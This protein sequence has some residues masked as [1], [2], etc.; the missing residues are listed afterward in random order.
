MAELIRIALIRRDGGTQPRAAL[1]PATVE[2]Y[3]EA[4]REGV[5]FP[6]IGLVYD[7]TDYWL[8]DGFHRT[9][10]FEAAGIDEIEAEVIAGT[11]RDAVLLA[12]GA[13]ATHGLRRTSDD[14]RRAVLLLLGDEEWGKWS[15]R[16]IAERARVSHTFVAKLRD[17]TG[18]VA[19]E[20]RF[21]TKHGTV[22]T[23]ETAAMGKRAADVATIRSLP[24]QAFY[25]VL[26][27]VKAKRQAGKAERRETRER[28]LGEKIAAANAALPAMAAAG[29]IFPVILGDPEWRFEP[30]SRI[31][32]MDRAPEN[33]YP[34]SATD[35]IASR[36]VH[37]IAAPD[38]T[39]FLWATAPM[40]RQALEV[41]AAWGFAYKTHCIWAKRRKGR[42]RGPGYW[43]TGEHE[44]LLLGTKGSPPAPAPGAQF[45]SF[46][47]ADVGEHSEKPAR[48]YELIEAYFPTLP[49]IE[50]NARAPREGWESW[51]AEA[52]EGAVA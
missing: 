27:D 15:D 45:P 22:S 3:A 26:A 43:F 51:G 17:L 31:T 39:L 30:W 13:N 35:V 41:M 42:A 33:H 9:A 1:D 38:C 2:T 11:R 10:G 52:P 16:E 34:T 48:A 36:P 49:K 44:I 37:L 28:E 32:G 5:R 25:D 23:M 40:L 29:R 8:W 19:S 14:K 4:A 12:A 50:L 18:N 20:R 46:F 7:G 24:V 47:I 21:T 6:A